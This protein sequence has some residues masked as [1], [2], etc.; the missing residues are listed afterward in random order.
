[1]VVQF[2]GLID[3]FVSILLG[4]AYFGTSIKILFMIA[5]IYLIAKGALF[6]TSLASVIDI[7]AGLLL[8][9]GYFFTVPSILFIILAV[10]L[11]QKGIFSF[12]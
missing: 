12:L 9:L 3:I 5:G 8:I 6:I 7:A 11:L 4:I 10:L 1:M 2:L